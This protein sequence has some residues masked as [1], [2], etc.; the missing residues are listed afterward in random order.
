MNKYFSVSD[1]IY[2]IVEKNPSSLEFFIANG[3]E[4]F[5]DRG[6]FEKMAKNV[7]LSMA[8]RLKGMNVELYEDKLVFFLENNGEEIE[9][10]ADVN[11]EGVLPCP[12]RVPLLEAFELWL[13]ENREDLGYKIGYDLKSANLGLDWIVEQVKTKD[14]NKVPDILMSAGFE[15]FFDKNLMGYFN[16]RNVFEGYVDEFNK[17]FSND[18]IDLRDPDNK[19]IITGVV[20]AVFVVNK[21]EL[22]GRKVPK[23]WA[24]ILSEEFED[25]VAVPMGDLD[26]FNALV[27]SLYKDYGMQGIKDLARSYMKS[28]HPAEMVKAKGKNN[29][30][31]VSI[32]PYF[33]TQMIDE[34]KQIAVWPEDGAVIS[35]IFMIVKKDKKEM[36]K[37]VIDFFTS[38]KIGKIFS[39]NGKFPSTNKKVD[40]FLKPEQ[41]F[42]WVGWDFIKNTDIGSLLKDLEA[43]FQSEINK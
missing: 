16:D 37:P 6:M 40:N 36:L 39:A 14:V 5:K 42:K 24:D 3:F 1:K 29:V 13:K 38:E 21:E 43:E 18:Y 7:S 34:N 15:L 31:C 19:Y 8:L 20:P 10:E 32:I 33:F 22:N 35:P 26:L 2:D 30:P 27:V 9:V 41:R 28:L 12:I 11:I 17:D 25:S 23:T 4:Q